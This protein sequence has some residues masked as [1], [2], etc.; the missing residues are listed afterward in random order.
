MA[1]FI[2][3]DDFAKHLADIQYGEA[4]TGRTGENID[5]QNG[6]YAG[7]DMAY[8]ALKQFPAA[9]VVTREAFN[10]I[11]AENDDMREQL[12]KIGKKP[13]DKMDDVAKVKR[14]VW[15]DTPLDTFRKFESKCSVCG[16]SGVSNYDGYVDIFDFNFCPACGA[17]MTEVQDG[18]Q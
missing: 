1:D 4:P 12:A 7:F 6:V 14:G 18:K 2:S 8:V 17:V 13:G 9:D 16:W 10:R 5:Y 11:L 3:R 15:I